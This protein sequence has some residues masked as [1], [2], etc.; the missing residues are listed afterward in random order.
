MRYG[1]KDAGPVACRACR[2]ASASLAVNAA[3]TKCCFLGGYA[4]WS[5]SR[6]RNSIVRTTFPHGNICCWI[7]VSDETH[8]SRG[9]ALEEKVNEI[10]VPRMQ[11]KLE[12]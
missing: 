9:G 12:G 1:H 8:A 7:L 5:R 2:P 11:F 10:H 3:T 4:I 6:T